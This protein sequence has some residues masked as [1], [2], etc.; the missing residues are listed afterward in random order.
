[1]I[2]AFY[3]ILTHY[4]ADFIFQP[5][6]WAT[7]KSKSFVNLAKHTFV[8]TGVFYIAF[9]LY[10]VYRLEALRVPEPGYEHVW[11]WFFPI[12]FVFHT[13]IDY[14]SSKVVSKKF[15]N[16][17]LGGNVPNTG[18][19][20]VIGFDQLLHYGTLFMTYEYVTNYL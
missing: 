15:K 5:E 18:A 2:E 6:E 9:C 17:D 3:L 19:F 20:S 7:T 13:C 10:I 16:N 12:T 8:Y 1:M 4:I 11:L 14:V